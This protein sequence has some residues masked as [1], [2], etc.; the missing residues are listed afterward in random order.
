[1]TEWSQH[2]DKF[3]YQVNEP[4]AL[5]GVGVLYYALLDPGVHDKRKTLKRVLTYL[6]RLDAVKDELEA[7]KERWSFAQID[8]GAF[9]FPQ[10]GIL[11]KQ[12]ETYVVPVMESLFGEL[13]PFQ[14]GR[15][16]AT[17]QLDA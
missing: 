3:A 9:D 12:I 5:S 8:W 17:A 13:H 11:K 15:K 2:E 7:A 14:E 6:L 16:L 4:H 1:L 10:V